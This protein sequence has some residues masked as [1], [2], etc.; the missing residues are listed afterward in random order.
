MNQYKFGRITC[1]FIITIVMFFNNLG[2]NTWQFW[3]VYL[4]AWGMALMQ[5]FEDFEG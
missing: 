3:L 2:I 4:S 5:Y 1:S